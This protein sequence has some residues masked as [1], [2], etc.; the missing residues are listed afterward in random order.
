MEDKRGLSGSLMERFICRMCGVRRTK[1]GRPAEFIGCVPRR[2]RCFEFQ[3]VFRVVQR[4]KLVKFTNSLC[5][6]TLEVRMGEYK[7]MNKQ[8]EANK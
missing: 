1:L 7:W 5:E 8:G 2:E 6:I 3:P 4:G